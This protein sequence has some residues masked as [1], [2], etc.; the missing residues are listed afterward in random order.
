MTLAKK[1]LGLCW[2][3]LGLVFVWAF[4]GMA[5]TYGGLGYL[6]HVGAGAGGIAAVGCMTASAL[7]GFALLVRPRQPL[8]LVLIAGVVASYVVAGVFTGEPVLQLL[9]PPMIERP[10]IWAYLLTIGLALV[11]LLALFVQSRPR[12]DK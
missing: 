4:I 2:F 7:I 1:F 8:L 12:R 10:L 11:T 3:A 9:M 5:H 6:A